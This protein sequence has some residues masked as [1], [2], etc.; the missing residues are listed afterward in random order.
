[1][2]ERPLIVALGQ[3]AAGDDGVGFAVLEELRRRGSRA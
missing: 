1:M 3:T 2:S